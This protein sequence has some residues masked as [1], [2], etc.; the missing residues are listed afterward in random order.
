MPY[1]A[2]LVLS[3][4]IIEAVAAKGERKVK[5]K[6]APPVRTRLRKTAAKIHLL[7]R[8]GTA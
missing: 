6:K 2:T 3:G 4:K 5:K 7:P 1:L 8:F